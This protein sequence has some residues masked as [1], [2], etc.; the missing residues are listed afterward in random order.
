MSQTKTALLVILFLFLLLLPFSGNKYYLHLGTFVPIMVILSLGLHIFFGLCGQIDFGINGFY[1]AGAYFAALLMKYLGLHYFLT[2]PLAMALSGVISV[3]VG[4][5][6]LKLRHW[7]L[8]LGTSAFGLAVWLTLR[9]VGVGV[10]GGDDGLFLPK[11]SVFDIKAGPVFYYYFIM[12][13]TVLACFCAYFLGRSRVGR[14]MKAIREDEIAASVMGINIDHYVRLSFIIHGIYAG[15]AGALYAQWN[16]WVSPG[17]FST[18]VG[19]SVLVFIVVGGV[20]SV[21]GAIVGAVIFTLLPELLIPLKE[22]HILIY[23]LI[24]F[25]V[26]R[27][28]SKG[29]IGAGKDLWM[30]FTSAEAK[31]VAP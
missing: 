20:G 26:I 30:R 3:I 12:A 4:F 6:V 24:F 16:G 5:A 13:W 19:M 23:A 7:V 2:L 1:A 31:Q 11:L 21:A 18:D 9:T 29:L 27:F 22:Y 25:F 14:A 15:L 28:M 10:L 17:S 8:A